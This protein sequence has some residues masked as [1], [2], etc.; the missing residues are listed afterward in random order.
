MIRIF[1]C[2]FSARSSRVP[3]KLLI[4]PPIPHPA[5]IAVI[6]HN[7]EAA[8]PIQLDAALTLQVNGF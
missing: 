6:I 5:H 8:E 3:E 2:Y 1:A 7:R 4:P